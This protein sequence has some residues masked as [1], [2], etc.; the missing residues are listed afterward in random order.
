MKMEDEEYPPSLSSGEIGEDHR[1]GLPC[2]V[3]KSPPPSPPPYLL[4]SPPQSPP[5]GPLGSSPP[6][7]LDNSG[8]L[9]FPLSVSQSPTS[10]VVRTG[11]P[12]PSGSEYYEYSGYHE[13]QTQ[14]FQRD[15]SLLGTPIVQETPIHLVDYAMPTEEPSHNKILSGLPLDNIDPPFE[16][17]G[18]EHI[19]SFTDLPRVP[20]QLRQLRSNRPKRQQKTHNRA[21]METGYKVRKPMELKPRELKPKFV[22]KRKV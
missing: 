5:L 4:D 21:P 3:P 20:P 11:T 6:Y 19:S 8:I 15:L 2:F 14:A 17:Q 10:V 16:S 22:T 12:F 9:Q 7:I 18:G 1:L 13:S